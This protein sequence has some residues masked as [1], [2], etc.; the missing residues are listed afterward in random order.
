MGLRISVHDERNDRIESERDKSCQG[1]K[2]P[3]KG[4]G[5]PGNQTDKTGP[6]RN[7]EHDAEAGGN[8]FTALELEV[9][10]KRMAQDRGNA[11]E[12]GEEIMGKQRWSEQHR[13]E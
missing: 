4:G 8:A 10:R 2:L 7:R 5:G 12:H 1:G 6:G 11:A 13:E 9:D 3:Q